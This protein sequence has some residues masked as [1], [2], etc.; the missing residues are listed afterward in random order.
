MAMYSSTEKQDKRPVNKL[1]DRA[2]SV[3][4]RIDIDVYIFQ[5]GHA[6]A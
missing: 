4:T 5:A 6:Q 3:G 1:R 2:Q